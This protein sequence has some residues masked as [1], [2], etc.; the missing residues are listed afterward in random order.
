MTSPASISTQSHCGMP[1]TRTP[2]RRPRAGPRP[3]DP[4]PT[5]MAVRPAR[6]HDHV[7]AERGF[8]AKID[9]EVSSAFMSSRRARTMRSVSSASGRTW[10]PV[11]AREVRPERLQVWTEVLILSVRCRPRLPGAST[12]ISACAVNFQLRS[13]PSSALPFE[14]TRLHS[15]P[16]LR[17]LRLPRRPQRR[18]GQRRF[19]AVQE[20]PGR[21][22]V[23]A[24]ARRRRSGNAHSGRAPGRRAAPA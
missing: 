23:P 4:R 2:A 12:K 18:R 1:S 21:R 22:R 10:R 3:R 16:G 14:T 8:V 24:S 15:C 17:L 9:G 7:V 13:V 6:G 20:N 5:Y 11:R 19:Q